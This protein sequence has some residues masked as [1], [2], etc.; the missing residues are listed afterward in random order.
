MSESQE[1]W[2]DDR[3]SRIEE[4][5]DK[6]SDA[7][8]SLARAEEKLIAIETSNQNQYKRINRMSEKIDNLESKADES[9]R[10]VKILYGIMYVVATAALGTMFKILTMNIH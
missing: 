10:A 2:R 3:L 1:S 4:K 9:H 7:M 8:I 5:I 6:L